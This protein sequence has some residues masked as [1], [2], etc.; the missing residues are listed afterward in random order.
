MGIIY[1][2]IGYVKSA[3][4]EMVQEMGCGYGEYNGHVNL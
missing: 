3:P 1:E 2:L 4:D